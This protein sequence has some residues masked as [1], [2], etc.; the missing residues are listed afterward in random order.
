LTSLPEN[1]VDCK[2]LQYLE[3]SQNCLTDL[4]STFDKLEQLREINISYNRYRNSIQNKIFKAINIKLNRFE[5]IPSC[6]FGNPGLEILLARDNKIKEIDSAGLGSIP[7][8]AALDLANNDISIVPPQL[9][10]LRLK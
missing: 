3:V 2:K 6:L 1:L 8:L 9:G 10:L 4:P 5:I 7:R